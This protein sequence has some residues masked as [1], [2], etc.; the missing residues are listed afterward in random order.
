MFFSFIFSI[1]SS[2]I[3]LSVMKEFTI[4]IEP[5][6]A[7]ALIP[8][9]GGISYQNDFLGGFYHGRFNHQIAEARIG[10]THVWGYSCCGKE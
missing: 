4:D 6:L 9:L 2:E 8:Y 1:F 5:K 7:N 3:L 10:Q